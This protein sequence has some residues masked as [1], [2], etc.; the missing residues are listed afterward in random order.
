MRT[1]LTLIVLAMAL[2]PA[3]ADLATGNQD[4]IN[5]HFKDFSAAWAKHDAKAVAAFYTPKAEIVTES[6]QALV[7]RDVIE[8]TLS[9]G[10][11]NDLKDSTLVINIEKTRLIKPDV[12]IVDAEVQIKHGDA[13]ANKLHLVSVLVKEDG[14]WVTETSRAIAYRQP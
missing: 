4:S 12:A 5:D 3:R 9:D 1:C 7:G 6:G 2:S 11:Q 14:K 13:E 8:Q 10:F